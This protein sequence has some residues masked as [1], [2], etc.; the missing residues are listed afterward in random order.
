MKIAKT[1][2]GALILLFSISNLADLRNYYGQ[3]TSYILGYI[4]AGSLFLLLGVYLL[5]SG[6]KP[7]NSDKLKSELKEKTDEESV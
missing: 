4:S 3:S 1:I 6:L 7:D 5:R 2:F